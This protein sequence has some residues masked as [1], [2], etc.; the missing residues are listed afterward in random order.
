MHYRN[1][2]EH[3]SPRTHC[4]VFLPGG[5]LAPLG[6]SGVLQP[7]DDLCYL[8][9]ARRPTAAVGRPRQTGQV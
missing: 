3:S 7:S 6:C 9:R 2:T 4:F 8:I 5:M 1:S